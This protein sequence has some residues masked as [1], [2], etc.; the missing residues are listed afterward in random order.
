MRTR[1]LI[2]AAVG[3]G[4]LLLVKYVVFGLTM[5][6]AALHP[7][8]TEPES[9]FAQPFLGLFTKGKCNGSCS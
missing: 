8:R 4:V 9:M 6:D 1:D 7:L 5:W 2:F 3:V